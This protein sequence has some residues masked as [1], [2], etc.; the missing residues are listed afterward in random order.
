MLLI[1]C[2]VFAALCLLRALGT[3]E[4][5]ELLAYDYSMRWRPHAP[6]DARLVVI[7]ETEDDIRRFGFPLADGLLAQ[8]LERLAAMS[9]RAIGVDKYRDIAV[10][11]GSA[12]LAQTLH[13]HPNIIWI[14]KFGDASDPYIAP[15]A[16]LAGTD[17][18]GFNGFV[19]DP[20]GI[21]RRGLLFLDDGKEVYHA[22]ALRL[23]LVYLQPLKIGLAPDP[24]NPDHVRIG[25]G[26]IVPFEKNDGGYN[27]A[28]A[29]GYQFLLDYRGM[30]GRFR[31]FTVSDLLA[32]R[33]APAAISERVV[34][35]GSSASTL[36]DDFYT[37][38]SHGLVTDQRLPGPHLH[39]MVTSQLLR[40]AL[41]ES[42]PVRT[43]GE[44]AEYGWI[45]LWCLLGALA[46]SQ[47]SSM[48]RFAGYSIVALGCLLGTGYLALIAGW[49]IPVVPPATGIIA[50]AGVAVAYRSMHERVQRSMLME[51]F[52]KHVSLEVAETLWRQ[53]DEF[54]QGGRPRPQQLVATVLFTDIRGFTKIS[55]QLDAPRVFQWLDE[56]MESMSRIVDKHH[57]IVDKYIGDAV[58]AVF[59]VPVARETRQ[60]IAGDALNAVECALE[61]GV[62]LARL[63]SAWRERSFPEINIRAGIFTGPLIAGS[64]G[65]ARKLEYTVIGDTVNTASRLESFEAGADPGAGEGPC[66]I[67]TA[68]A[69]VKHLGDRYQ[70]RLIGAV[71]LKGKQEV[72]TV[73]QILGRTG[74]STATA[75][76]QR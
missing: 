44:T 60:Q 72:I 75:K 71:S 25:A 39:A 22:F 31:A 68:D 28:D 24:V 59:G 38:Y 54:L 19:D 12:Q 36:R 32:D 41:G 2:G 4:P 53:R 33:I 18:A 16:A 67:L 10:P 47:A 5:L 48:L 13:R 50:A 56:Y 29:R 9:P 3:F 66:R 74:D 11:P 42:K 8:L 15:P 27:N 55:E 52:S 62:E 6:T 1:A 61:M 57:G 14:M 21:V 7:E 23:A 70:T 34:I 58:M 63:N 40:I 69:T 17:R 76:G 46:G 30:P 51:I 73:L 26:T 43:W 65:G 37:P 64:I 45:A 35:I 49:W 20:G